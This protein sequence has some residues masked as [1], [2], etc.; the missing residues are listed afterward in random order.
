MVL[1]KNNKVKGVIFAEDVAED[2]LAAA[3]NAGILV[4]VNRGMEDSYGCINWEQVCRPPPP[5]LRR[6]R[7]SK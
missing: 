3:T 6:P 5:V 1:A 2:I 7:T 4:I